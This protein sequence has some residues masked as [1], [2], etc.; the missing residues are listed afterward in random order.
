MMEREAAGPLDEGGAGDGVDDGV[1]GGAGDPMRG[2]PNRLDPRRMS[3]WSLFVVAL[4]VYVVSRLCVLVGAAIV[5]AEVRVDTNLADEQGLPIAD[6]HGAAPLGNAVRPMIDVLTSWDGLWYLDIVRFGYPRRIPPD[7]TYHIEEARAAFFPLFPLLGRATDA[8]LPGGDTVAVL[9]LNHALGLVAIVLIGLLGRRLY[10]ERVAR[11]SM[12]L[13]ALFPGSFV[14]SFAYSEALMIVLA[15]AC[16]LLL[17]DREWVAA[18]VFA[19]LATA[20]RPNGLALVVACGVAALFAIRERR[21]WRALIAVALAPVGFVTFQVWLGEHTGE[22]G[23]W[24]RVQRE[25][26]D[27]GASFGLTAIRNTVE[28]ITHP[29][30]SPTDTITAVTAVTT[31]ALV[32][33]A[34]R[35]R[36]DWTVSVYSWV[37]VVLML[38]PATVTARPRFLFTAFP[39]LIGAAAWYERREVH[40]EEF[41]WTLVVAAC[42][43]GLVGLTGLYGSFG[44]IP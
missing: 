26:W 34:W 3:W 14:L 12:V 33:M 17:L 37:I 35:T 15:A 28:A 43:A 41:A 1:D 44:A 18:G 6:P 20:T 36:L 23:A 27:E 9:V 2:V 25:A 13:G 40:D 30:T 8:V 11:R 38:A 16:L 19:A 29:L 24:F 10:D 32:V 39:L 4:P 31:V 22:T 42:G 21:E 7:V 5:A